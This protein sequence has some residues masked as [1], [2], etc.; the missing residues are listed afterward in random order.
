M[1]L[2]HMN[3]TSHRQHAIEIDRT[4]RQLNQISKIPET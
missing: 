3:L 2:E 1:E 4:T